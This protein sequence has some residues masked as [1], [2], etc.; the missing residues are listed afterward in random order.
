MI[1]EFYREAEKNLEISAKTQV[2][3]A[4]GGIAGVAAAIAAAR[5]G[6]EVLLLERE[7]GLGGLATLGLIAIYLP[8]DDGLG[9]QVIYGIGEEL[10]KLSILHGCEGAS[11]DAWLKKSSLEERKKSRYVAQF[12]PV[13]FALEME[14]MLCRLGVKILY[15]SVATAVV[16]ENDRIKGVIIEN[17]SGRSVIS[18]DVCIDCTGDADIA[19]LAGADTALHGRGNGLADWYYYRDGS[20]VKLKMFGLADLPN[21]DEKPEEGASD[22]YGNVMVT[23]LAN[24]RFSGVD[25]PELSDA[26]QQAHRKMYEDILAG[27]EKNKDYAPVAMSS[28]PLVRMSR[29]VV[30][31]YTMDDSENRIPFEDSIG[32]TGDW[33]KP[34]PCYEIPFRTLYSKKVPN[35]ICAG[36]TIS[37]TDPMWEITRVIPPCAVTGQAAGT[38]AALTNDFSRLD[39]TALQSRLEKQ[40]VRLHI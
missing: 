32:L 33:R 3:V 40:K 19:H 39:V 29:R 9:E 13:M 26:V 17:K 10:L 20:N 5:N 16:K 30:G 23:S 12:N 1:M 34:G 38:A 4:G 25:G 6:S 37:V 7:Y 28:I 15:G 31:E 24:M 2:L 14:S 35:L 21:I 22:P 27:K 36:R 8:L 11:P 18:C